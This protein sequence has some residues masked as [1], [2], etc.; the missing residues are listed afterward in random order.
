MAGHAANKVVEWKA[1]RAT[2]HELEEQLNE[3]A[4]EGWEL[5]YMFPPVTKDQGF[6]LVYK[7]DPPAGGRKRASKTMGFPG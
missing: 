5:L 2:F 4:K 1:V 3:L 6:T 7:K